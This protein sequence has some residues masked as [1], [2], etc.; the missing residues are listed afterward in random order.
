ML[1]N[2]LLLISCHHAVLVLSGAQRTYSETGCRAFTKIAGISTVKL[3]ADSQTQRLPQAITVWAQETN[4]TPASANHS[5]FQPPEQ[6]RPRVGLVVKRSGQ[7]HIVPLIRTL[8]KSHVPSIPLAS[9]RGWVECREIWWQTGS[10]YCT[11]AEIP[12][13]DSIC[14]RC[15][16]WSGQ[17]YLCACSPCNKDVNKHCYPHR[18]STVISIR[19]SSDREPWPVFFPAMPLPLTPAARAWG[20]FLLVHGVSI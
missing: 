6:L 20:D 11:S 16:P 3:G 4:L 12:E 14:E 5:L 15:H 9:S 2:V 19:Q 7:V 1:S 8:S 18:S 13:P 17:A 10:P